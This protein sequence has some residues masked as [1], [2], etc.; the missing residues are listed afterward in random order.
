[1]RRHLITQEMEMHIVR[2]Y[3]SGLSLRS[4]RNETGVGEPN[5]RWVLS[6]HGVQMHRAPGRT[7]EERFLDL[8]D[9]GRPGCWLWIGN[10]DSKGYG[11]FWEKAMD[12]FRKVLAHRWSYQH[13]SGP[14]P[15]G[16]VIDHLCRNRSCVN[17]DHLEHVTP[18]ENDRRGTSFAAVNRRKTHCK[19][20]HPFDDLNTHYQPRGGRACRECNKLRHLGVHPRMKNKEKT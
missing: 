15:D 17:P 8:V 14:I 9:R 18:L 1:M 16:L 4:V 12:G 10:K 19:W 2:L 7:E 13:F 3:S 20:G 6:K 11:R 5:I